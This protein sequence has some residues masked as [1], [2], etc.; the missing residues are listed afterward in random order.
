MNERE[1]ALA[2]ADDLFVQCQT[3]APWTVNYVDLEESLAVGSIAQETLAQGGI[4]YRF[5]GLSDA[6]RDE[7][8]YQREASEW[9]VS[10]LS[11]LSVDHWPDLVAGSYLC[12]LASLRA[13]EA[14]MDTGESAQEQLRIVHSEQVLHVTHWRKWISLLLG[15]TETE[16]EM[17]GALDGCLKRGGDLLPAGT[18]RD[19]IHAQWKS[20]VSADLT[21]WGVSMAVGAERTNRSRGGE[22]V[23]RLLDELRTA[24]S[25]GGRS[26][27]AIY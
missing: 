17:V 5:A 20:D 25:A 1:V 10:T 4:L 19:H 14:L 22:K 12:A 9:S 27:Y 13:V 23:V 15:N 3:L 21:A 16:G 7:R 18:D 24:R 11:F 26:N 6:E 2:L 8:V